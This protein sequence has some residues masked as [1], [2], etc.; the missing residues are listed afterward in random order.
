MFLAWNLAQKRCDE[1][2]KRG[3]KNCTKRGGQELPQKGGTRMAPKGGDKN[4][5]K[6]MGGQE[7]PPKGDNC[8]EGQGCTKS[9]RTPQI[10][11][12]KK[13]RFFLNPYAPTLAAPIFSGHFAS[14][15]WTD[16]LKIP[17]HSPKISPNFFK[18]K[19]N[20]KN[21]GQRIGNQS[22]GRVFRGTP[23]VPHNFT[24]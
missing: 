18:K 20:V 8:T 9:S 21:V 14:R 3:D 17:A 7:L 6:S 23:R 15:F 13:C 10:V 12:Q 2:T 22:W 4:C 24:K 5:T 19:H 11:C 1:I 16:V